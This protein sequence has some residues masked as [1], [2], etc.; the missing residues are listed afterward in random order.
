MG[1]SATA[2]CVNKT[3]DPNTSLPPKCVEFAGYEWVVKKGTFDPSSNFWS[4]DSKN[5]SVDGQG[6]HLG[7]TPRDIPSLWQS[8]EVI[9]NESLGYGR[10]TVTTTTP[11]NQLDSNSVLGF[12]TYNFSD[13]AFTHREIDIEFSPLIGAQRGTTE[14]FSVQSAPETFDFVADSSPVTTHS[15]EW[16][17]D[18]IVFQS[19]GHAWTYAGQLVPQTGGEHFRINLWLNPLHTSNISPTS[20]SEVHVVISNF[21]FTP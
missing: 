17:S 2:S 1:P 11:A 21:T 14:H 5:V 10:Y 18:R 13:S 3:G 7:I 15:F 20:K 8:S 12:F 4:D 19:G 16:R 9:L 6:L